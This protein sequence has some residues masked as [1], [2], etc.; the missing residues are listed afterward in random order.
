MMYLWDSYLVF[1][2]MMSCYFSI[3]CSVLRASCSLEECSRNVTL[4]PCHFSRRLHV[5]SVVVCPTWK[6]KWFPL[7]MEFCVTFTAVGDEEVIFLPT[8]RWGTEARKRCRQKYIEVPAHFRNSAW[9]I[10]ALI[11]SEYLAFSI[12]KPK[13]W[14]N[15]TVSANGAVAI[16]WVYVLLFK[17]HEAMSLHSCYCPSSPLLTVELLQG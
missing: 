11:F 5:L 6:T 1:D 3:L 2:Y 16:R 14:L 4:C 13:D 10:W 8:Y 9:S 17:I 7:H 12:L 15:F